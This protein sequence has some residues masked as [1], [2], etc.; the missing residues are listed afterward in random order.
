MMLQM[1]LS[2]IKLIK[3]WTKVGREGKEELMKWVHYG[4][5]GSWVPGGGGQLS[6]SFRA[7][8]VTYK[9]KEQYYTM[10]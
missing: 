1:N 3:P 7:M 8:K 2:P 6:T 5:V 9:A 4:W 10:K